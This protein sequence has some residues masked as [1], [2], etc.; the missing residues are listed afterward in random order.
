MRSIRYLLS[1]LLIFWSCVN[2]FSQ[3]V[4]FE[5]NIKLKSGIAKSR[6][7][8]PVTNGENGCV[9][10]L[11]DHQE[12]SSIVINE[13]FLMTDSFAIGRAEVPYKN[14]LGYSKESSNYHLFFSNKKKNEFFIQ[15]IN[16]VKKQSTS[17]LFELKLK[18]EKMLKAFSYLDNFYVLT[19]K[20]MSSIL[21]L[22]Q[23]EGNQ[24][25]I[26]KE[27]DFSEHKFSYGTYPD[28]YSAFFDNF[29]TLA[30]KPSAAIIDPNV[31]ISVET[32]AESSKI[33]YFNEAVHLTLDHNSRNTILISIHLKSFDHI[34]KYID[35][36]QLSCGTYST[37]LS[38]SF[39]SNETIFQIKACKSELAIQA[40]KVETGEQIMHYTVHKD[41]AIDFKNSPV[42]VSGGGLFFGGGETEIDKTKQILKHLIRGKLGIS[43][44]RSPDKIT[45]TLGGYYYLPNSAAGMGMTY[46]PGFTV[47][48]PG[49]PVTVPGSY[50]HNPTMFGY[51]NYSNSISTRFNALLNTSTFEHMKGEITKNGFDKIKEFEDAQPA[52]LY[53]KT[54][55]KIE[56]RYILGYYDK[57]KKTYSL[58]AFEDD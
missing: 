18:K 29:N 5:K 27:F 3:D 50:S 7:V 35:K 38:N 39:L 37:T 24:M 47:S 15:T 10:F 11:L 41:E 16:P 55:F 30:F 6:E 12:I 53:A 13:Q 34:I 44:Y 26:R 51:G 54:I 21:A 58:L 22:Y 52:I 20:K 19:I 57:N 1:V 32:A 2:V 14:L 46:N 25:T 8:L 40:T 36:P 4:L 17:K 31:P 48:T 43:A 9:L 42:L 49:G 23:F 56:N 33:Y 28:M 45:L